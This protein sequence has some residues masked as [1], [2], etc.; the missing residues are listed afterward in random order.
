VNQTV[1]CNVQ[2]ENMALW[3]GC[4]VPV[5]ELLDSS[6]VVIAQ[7]EHTVGESILCHEGWRRGF[8]QIT[9]GFLVTFGFGLGIIFSTD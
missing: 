3:C 2:R 5:Y 9:L 4:G 6:A 1:Q 8:S 7:L